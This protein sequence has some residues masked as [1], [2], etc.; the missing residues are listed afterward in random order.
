MTYEHRLYIRAAI[1]HAISAAE[2]SLANARKQWE[3]TGDSFWLD[4]IRYWDHLH[5]QYAEAYL[6]YIH[7]TVHEAN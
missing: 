5:N 1:Q 4:S 7:S 3:E 2:A 6:A